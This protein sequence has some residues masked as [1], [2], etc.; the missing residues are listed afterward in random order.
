MDPLLNELMRAI[1]AQAS[2]D[3]L[4]DICS[5][6]EAAGIAVYLTHLAITR[7]LRLN[8]GVQRNPVRISATQFIGESEL[9][10]TGHLKNGIVFEDY[11]GHANI[12]VELTERDNGAVSFDSSGRYGIGQPS[13]ISIAIRPHAQLAFATIAALELKQANGFMLLQRL[14]V[15]NLTIKGLSFNGNPQ[16]AKGVASFRSCTITFPFVNFALYSLLNT[17]DFN[18]C[19]F[20]SEYKIP[21]NNALNLSL[22]RCRFAYGLE[23]R[24]ESA[25]PTNLDLSYANVGE[26]SVV[27]SGTRVSG[28]FSIS[29]LTAAVIDLHGGHFDQI[30]AINPDTTVLNLDGARFL[31]FNLDEATLDTLSLSGPAE[32]TPKTRTGAVIIND[33]SVQN[34]RLSSNVFSSLALTD[35]V[36]TKLEAND[37]TFAGITN[38]EG[39]HFSAAPDFFETKFYED[40]SFANTRFDD[41]S[42]A[43][44]GPYRS[45]KNAMS[46]I[47]NDIDESRFAGYEMACR[48]KSMPIKRENAIELFF[49]YVYRG[50]NSYGRA[51]FRP[52]ILIGV[53]F[54][55]FS[56]SYCYFD[57]YKI[58][59]LPNDTWIKKISNSSPK[60]QA[61]FISGLNTLGPLK[62]FFEERYVIALTPAWFFWSL[63]QSAISTVLWFFAV[64]GI[65]K[66]FKA[67]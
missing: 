66:R 29:G 5:R 9:T 58:A 60:M 55:I 14:D 22:S 41:E 62:I 61:L 46:K 38:F 54:L 63:I 3:Q 13:S 1:A 49:L 30:N 25:A 43:A 50:I 44:L 7:K 23:M 10:I 32:V 12:E 15:E 17:C 6:I 48:H 26:N 59:D 40:T 19:Q 53:L 57:A 18:T 33:S 51:P 47:S 20:E 45:L 56:T 37:S 31:S 11:S 67:T 8:L 39:T 4:D 36:V 24:K 34:L 52:L 27:I 65:R 35:C 28:N 2:Q 21:A 42:K 16:R 64:L